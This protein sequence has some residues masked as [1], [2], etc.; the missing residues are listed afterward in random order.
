VRCY[1]CK[2][3]VTEADSA[4]RGRYV[5]S[6]RWGAKVGYREFRRIRLCRT[7]CGPMEWARIERDR[8][9]LARMKEQG[10]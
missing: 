8:A 3:R 1:D 5:P 6:H 9:E 4:I 2:K 10:H 7:C